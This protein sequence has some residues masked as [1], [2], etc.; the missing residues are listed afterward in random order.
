LEKEK[1]RLAIAGIS[2]IGL[3]A[4]SLLAFT[5][6]QRNTL[7]QQRPDVQDKSKLEIHHI[8]PLYQGGDSELDNGEALLRPF[9]ALEH[10]KNAIN[11]KN[12]D[13]ASA[14]YW[15]VRKIVNRMS[16]SELEEFNLLIKKEGKR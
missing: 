4:V 12:S 14:E 8:T 5:K 11:A 2:L 1:E 3:Y 16:Q 13:T 9:H 15:A 7:K 6:D 10:Y